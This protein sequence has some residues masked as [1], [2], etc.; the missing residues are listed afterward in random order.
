MLQ[1]HEAEIRNHI[2]TEHQLRLYIENMESESE[3]KVSTVEKE[4]LK[5]KSENKLLNEKLSKLSR[6]MSSLSQIRTGSKERV[7]KESIEDLKSSHQTNMVSSRLKQRNYLESFRR[8]KPS[9]LSTHRIEGGRVSAGK[10][11]TVLEQNDSQEA[12][13]LTMR[14]L[15]HNNHN[16][17]SNPQALADE[18]KKSQNK[19]S[20]TSSFQRLLTTYKKSKESHKSVSYGGGNVG[21]ALLV[22]SRNNIFA[23]HKATYVRNEPDKEKKTQ[24]SQKILGRKTEE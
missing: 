21:D 17:V 5:L 13:S 20:F 18:L 11:Q 6:E 7:S 19:S 12:A 4:N 23:K 22:K 1:K 8:T 24:K 3:A 10:H 16:S 15:K 9:T 2:R 14:R